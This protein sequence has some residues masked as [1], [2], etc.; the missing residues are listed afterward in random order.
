MHDAEQREP[1]KVPDVDGRQLRDAVN[2]HAGREP[3]V[4]DL[5]ALDFVREEKLPPAVM[6]VAAVR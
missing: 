5:Y 3:R 2:I 4:M 1:L 6:H